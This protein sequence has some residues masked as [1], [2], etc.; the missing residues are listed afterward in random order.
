MSVDE[1]ARLG[2][3]RPLPAGE[4]ARLVDDAARAGMRVR[5]DAAGIVH[6]SD[7]RSGR[8]TDGLAGSLRALDRTGTAVEVA[9]PADMAWQYH[10]HAAARSAFAA[11]NL[12]PFAATIGLTTDHVIGVARDCPNAEAFAMRIVP[13][14]PAGMR[15]VDLTVAEAALSALSAARRAA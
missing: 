9:H 8:V 12:G 2:G 10:R 1:Y 11:G 13:V 3:F 4:D 15:Q 5:R 7:R 14:P 6:T